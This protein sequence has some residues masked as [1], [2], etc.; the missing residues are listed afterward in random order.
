MSAPARPDFFHQ[1]FFR[2][3]TPPPLLF[4]QLLFPDNFLHFLRTL[5]AAAGTDQPLFLGYADGDRHVQHMFQGHMYGMNRAAI[6][7]MVEQGYF[8]PEHWDRIHLDRY[9]RSLFPDEDHV[10]SYL[11]SNSTHVNCAQFVAYP[12]LIG[13]PWAGSF[14]KERVMRGIM[15]L[16]HV[17]KAR[18]LASQSGL[19]CWG[20]VGHY[21]GWWA[22]QMR[23][24]PVTPEGLCCGLLPYV[25]F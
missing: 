4:P 5:E 6:E 18:E 20:A 25:H 10:M 11:N 21:G 19:R 2:V 12:G 17:D 13:R 16:H 15:T 23:V 24:S 22:L 9:A 8:T 7:P 14:T 1:P 3:F